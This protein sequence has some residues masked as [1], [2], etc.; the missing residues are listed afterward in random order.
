[1]GYTILIG[2]AELGDM[3]LDAGE[4]FAGWG[5]SGGGVVVP[6]RTHIS[7]PNLPYD[8]SGQTNC[9]ELGY[10]H[11]HRLLHET[12]LD[13]I[14]LTDAGLMRRHPGTFQLTPD[15]VAAVTEAR[16]RWESRPRTEAGWDWSESFAGQLAPDDGVRGRDHTRAELLWLEWWITWA[17]AN[18]ERP[19]LHNH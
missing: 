7:A 5:E 14:F 9:R 19:A 12:G 15:H 18:C 3:Q 6:K 11:T 4:Y 8:F 10:K 1:M 17:V 2:N 16:V 13:R